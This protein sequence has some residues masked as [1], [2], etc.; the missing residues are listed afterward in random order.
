MQYAIGST[1]IIPIRREPSH[2]SEMV[3]QLLFGE[4]AEVLQT[5]KNFWQIR[6]LF[7]QYEGW[8]QAGQLTTVSAEN[9]QEAKLLGYLPDTSNIL[10][11][12]VGM[13]VYGGTPVWDLQNWAELEIDYGPVDPVNEL[14][15]SEKS[16]FGVLGPYINSSYLWGGRTTAGVDCSGLVQQVYKNFGINMPRDAYQ[17]AEKGTLIGFLEEAG[18]G[19]LAFFDNPEG[20]ITHVGIIMEHQKIVHASGQVRIDLLD[21]QGIIQEKS[22]QRTHSLRIIK[23]VT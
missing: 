5:E 13:V 9:V 17:Q 19:D 21:A 1:P 22:R 12:E 23:R 8:V 7:D 4:L 10:V 11:N 3:S 18:P 14:T 6:T 20:R 15:F 16:L 2:R